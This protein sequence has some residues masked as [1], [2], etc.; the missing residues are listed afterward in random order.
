MSDNSIDDAPEPA[1]SLASL[2]EKLAEAHH[3]A[4]NAA[5]I[6]KGLAHRMHDLVLHKYGLALATGH[7]SVRANFDEAMRSIDAA[8][9][10]ADRLSKLK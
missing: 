2:Q 3:A 5:M 1:E 8:L 4:A 7:P 9:M 10:T 6:L